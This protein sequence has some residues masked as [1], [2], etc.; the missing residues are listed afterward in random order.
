MADAAPAATPHQT[1]L[2]ELEALPGKLWQLAVDRGYSP[3]AATEIQALVADGST[4][5]KDAADVVVAA[6]EPALV[7]SEV[8]WP[9]PLLPFAPEIVSFVD[10]L[11][12]KERDALKAKAAA[13]AKALDDKIAAWATTK[14]AAPAPSVF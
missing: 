4:A 11:I 1:L 8:F 3:A 6:G 12:E 13:E 2:Q 9:A 5:V 14:A 10:G 7:A